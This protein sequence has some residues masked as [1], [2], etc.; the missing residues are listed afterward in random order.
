MSLGQIFKRDD[1][2]YGLG[3][4]VTASILVESV[5]VCCLKMFQEGDLKPPV[6]RKTSVHEG[7]FHEDTEPTFFR[8]L[9][10]L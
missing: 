7:S 4:G 3:F 5:I 2:S 9:R 8:A 1:Y 10:S 6:G